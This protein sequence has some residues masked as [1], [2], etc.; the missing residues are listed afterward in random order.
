MAKIKIKVHKQVTKTPESEVTAN[1]ALQRTIEAHRQQTVELSVAAKKA[2]GI[3]TFLCLLCFSANAQIFTNE[4]EGM[5]TTLDECSKL[6]I[7]YT[8]VNILSR[9]PNWTEDID[10][11]PKTIICT[12]ESAYRIIG[13]DECVQESL[14]LPVWGDS[15]NTPHLVGFDTWEADIA[16]WARYTVAYKAIHLQSARE[17]TILITWEKTKSGETIHRALYKVEVRC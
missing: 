8:E 17:C 16:W 2:S 9:A 14:G 15:V 3:I 7:Q 13:V 6:L 11:I 10:T 5:F 12:Y 1:R 4:H